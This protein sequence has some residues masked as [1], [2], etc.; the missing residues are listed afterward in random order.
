MNEPILTYYCR[1]KSTPYSWYFFSF[2]LISWY[3]CHKRWTILIHYCW[4]KSIL[5]LDFF[6]FFSF[7]LIAFSVPRPHTEHH[8]AFTCHVFYGFSRLWQFLELCLFLMG[9]T[10][11][12]STSWVFRW[13]SLYSQQQDSHQCVD[14]D[15]S[16]LAKVLFTRLIRCDS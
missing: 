7:Y 13:T 15:T 10:V 11:L 9:S 6:F 3:V 8:I 12:R 16:H 4:P 2:Y 14:I 5:H 1:L